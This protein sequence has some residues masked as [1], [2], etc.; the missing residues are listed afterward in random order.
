MAGYKSLEEAIRLGCDNIKTPT[1]EYV[2]IDDACMRVSAKTIESFISVPNFDRSLMDGYT[3]SR[4]DVEKLNSGQVLPLQ[5]TATI[6][7]GSIEVLHQGAGET[8]RIM[9]GALVPAGC[10]AIIKQEDVQ[11]KGGLILAQGPFKHGENIQKIGDE[12]RAGDEIALQGQLL[13][14][15]IVERIAA[16]GIENVLVYKVPHVY[17]INTG[18]ELLLPGSAIKTGQIYNSNRSLISGKIMCTGAQPLFADGIVR[19]DLGAITAEIKRAVQIA[20]MVIISGGT[21]N[22]VCDLVYQAFEDINADLLFRGIDIIPGKKTSA[23]VYNG[24]LLFNLSGNSY[25]AGLLFEALVEPIL[26]KLKGESSPLRKWFDIELGSPIKRIKS[27]RCLYRGEMV[28]EPPQVYAQ[29]VSR[30]HITVNNIPL[31]LDLSAGQG[32]VGDMVKAKLRY[33]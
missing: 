4:V 23:A 3:V 5:V 2:K 26:L 8:C 21:G 11:T 17:V 30:K 16:S 33:S 7:A 24:K 13:N 6:E 15:E 31:I 10:T 25:S 1:S 22:G 32:V 14:A 20:D 12:L 28:I 27:E 29:P 19:D 9:T 18:S